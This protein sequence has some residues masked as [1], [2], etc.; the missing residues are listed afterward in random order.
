MAQGIGLVV[1]PAQDLAAAKA[2]YTRLLGVAPYVDEPYYVGY[3]VGDQEVGLDP[4]GNTPGPI[5]YWETADIAS[6]IDELV[7]A[8]A[9]ER[10]AVRDVGGGLLVASV[11]DPAGNVIG[12]RQPPS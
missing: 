10:D 5:P 3:R 11:T 6:T 4:H 12:L 1:F 2:L 8:G 7:A 9:S